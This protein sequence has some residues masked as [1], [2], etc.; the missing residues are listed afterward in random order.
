VLS[1][2]IMNKS[3]IDSISKTAVEITIVGGK[4]VYERGKGK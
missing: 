3:E 1:R 4:V 2:D